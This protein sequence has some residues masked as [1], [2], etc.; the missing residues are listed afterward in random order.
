MH[1]GGNLSVGGTLTYEDV[2]N[3][4]AIGIVTAQSGLRVVGGGVTCVGV[5]TFF[6]AINHNNRIQIS[7]NTIYDKT[8]TGN[9]F[10]V[11]FSSTGLL[12]TNGGGTATNDSH[13]LGSSSKEWRALYV[14][15]IYA[16]GITT[17]AGDLS[18]AQKIVHT[19]DT[20]TFLEFDTDTI[21]F[22]TNGGEKLRIGS[23]GIIEMRSNMQTLGNQNIIRF[24]DTDTS[25]AAGQTM[26]RLQWYSSDASGG[27]ACVK[28]EIEAVCTDTTPDAFLAFKTHDG[29]GTTPETRLKLTSA[30][31]LLLGTTVDSVFNGGR[32]ASFQ[33][34]GT[35]A[36]TSA[37]AITRNS[38]DADPSYISLGKSRGT[39]V[40]ANTAVENGDDIGVIEFNAGDGSGSFNAHALIKGSVGAAPGNSDAPGRLSFWTTP[41]GGSTTPAE[42][43]RITPSGYVGIGTISPDRRLS[44]HQDATARFNIKSLADSTA[45]IEFGDTADHNIG[46]IVYDNTADSMQFGVNASLKATITS[47]GDINLHN[48]TA[49]SSTDPITVDFGGQYT[50]DAS[51]THQNL[52]VK[53]FSNASGNDS[54]GFTMGQSGVS[55]VSSVGAGHLF[56]TA[57]SSVN[58]I[59]ERMRIRHDG[60]IGI[61]TTGVTY[62]DHIYLSIRGNST[63]RGGVVHLGNSD[64]SV[65]AQLSIYD[66]K[67]WW[68]TGTS[69]PLVWGTGGASQMMTLSTAGHLGIGANS[70]D[71]T[72]HLA[73]NADAVIRLENTSAMGQDAVV[74]SVEFEKQDASG[75]GAGICGAVKCLSDDSYGARTYLAFTVRSNSTGAAATDTEIC[76]MTPRGLQFL[77][78]TS[79]DNALAYYEEGT[80]T[81]VVNKSGDAGSV[82]SYNTQV[83]RYVRVGKLLWISFYIYKSSGSFGSLNNQW[84]ISGLPFGLEHSAAGAYQSIPCGYFHMNGSAINMTTANS[85]WQ[86]NSTNGNT[87][88]TMYGSGSQ[89]NWTSGQ[90][91]MSG[92]GVLEID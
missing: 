70:P 2:T 16:S 42:R 69:H 10:G 56:Y 36:A 48:R 1:V 30:G 75:A 7:N 9:N 80:W 14:D 64:H 45:G 19:G 73:G 17:V 91:E 20:D 59:L 4:D 12:P 33:Q 43:L 57:P 85:R 15:D 46:Y 44:L 55:Y 3:V 61:N 58:T 35:N 81:P 77:G 39:S 21:M 47:V 22:D 60:N 67:A 38:D 86:S 8:G 5:A 63:S 25:V 28:A 37:L 34:E 78:E 82:T 83:G 89:T 54:G 90:L 26:G 23:D 87:T 62:S 18:I 92:T 50:P 72:L 52:K 13:D 32:N 6:G 29:S 76:R 79:S 40:G 11:E 84:Y 74:G 68:H 66:D 51:I 53:L 27:G 49:A 41:D 24:T 65:T 88:I 71:T 31:R